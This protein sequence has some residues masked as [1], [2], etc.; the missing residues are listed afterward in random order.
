ME[1]CLSKTNKLVKLVCKQ[2]KRIKRIKRKTL[3]LN[4]Q[5]RLTYRKFVVKTNNPLR[6]LLLNNLLAKLLSSQ[7]KRTLASCEGFFVWQLANTIGE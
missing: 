6:S 3:Q 5:A 7:W 1:Q 2:T 4:S